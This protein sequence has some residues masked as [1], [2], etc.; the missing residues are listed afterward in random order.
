MMYSNKTK[1]IIKCAYKVHN[2]LGSGFLEK[3]YHRC[4]QIEC[5]K[6]G[7]NCISEKPIAI[8]YDNQN[9]G[10][11]VTDLIIDNEILI[12]RNLENQIIM[13]CCQFVELK[14]SCLPGTCR[15]LCSYI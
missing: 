14:C 3:I 1:I 4:M 5:K 7:L 6:L 10:N 2:T 12:I 15:T 8:Y 9:V 13:S 11:Y